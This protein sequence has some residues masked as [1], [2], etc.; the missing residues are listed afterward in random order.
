MQIDLPQEVVER[1]QRL[2]LSGE[3]AAAVLARGVE[4]VE[5]RQQEVAA[6]REGIEAYKAGDFEPLE[7][8]DR[9][10]R[11]ERSIGPEA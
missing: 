5:W 2:A 6:I 8:F 1:A 4:L 9:R 7:D 3:D 11:A 10:F